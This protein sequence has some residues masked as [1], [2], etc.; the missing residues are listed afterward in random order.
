MA[1]R[2]RA[3]A[4]GALLLSS[5][6]G[7]RGGVVATA[8]AAEPP[9]AAAAASTSARAFATD[10]RIYAACVLERLPV[11]RVSRNRRAAGGKRE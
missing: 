4:Q 6:I 8:A 5:A 7:R 10:G 2:Q 11:S 3:V 1:L 9:A